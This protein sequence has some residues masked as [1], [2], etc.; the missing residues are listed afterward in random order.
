MFKEWKHKP[1]SFWKVTSQSLELHSNF[2]RWQTTKLKYH[3]KEY[4]TIIISE[5]Q[6]PFI[7]IKRI[8]DFSK[9]ISD[10]YSP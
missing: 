9:N 2:S 10:V 3:T 7:R 4:E 6:A 1:L 5:N 8:Y